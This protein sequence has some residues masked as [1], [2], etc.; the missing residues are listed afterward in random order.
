MAEVLQMPGPEAQA[1]VGTVAPVVDAWGCLPESAGSDEEARAVGLFPG[2]PNLIPARG[3]RRA[4]SG[5]VSEGP[6]ESSANRET[7]ETEDDDFQSTIP[8]LERLYEQLAAK[9]R[10]PGQPGHGNS[11]SWV[12]SLARSYRRLSKDKR[13]RG[14]LRSL[15]QTAAQQAAAQAQ[16]DGQGGASGSGLAQHLREQP[17]WSSNTDDSGYEAGYET[18]ADESELSE[19]ESGTSRRGHKRK[20]DALVHL[21]MRLGFSEHGCSE[22]DGSAPSMVEAPQ[23][24]PPPLKTPRA[25]CG[26]QHAGVRLPLPRAGDSD[27]LVPARPPTPTPLLRGPGPP[28]LPLAPAWNLPCSSPFA[29]GY[30]SFMSGTSVA[31]IPFPAGSFAPVLAPAAIPLPAP[32]FPV[33]PPLPALPDGCA[34]QAQADGAPRLVPDGTAGTPPGSPTKASAPARMEVG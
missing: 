31:G 1:S 25:P 14:R 23:P 22:S 13:R 34:F 16:Q 11:S 24:Q 7:T 12:L 20:L 33:S 6:S 10:L 15:L 26:T 8:H 17:G 30:P 19:W 4:H 5:D 3:E 27:A 28:A 9:A 18:D 29:G 21:T 32:A 2:L